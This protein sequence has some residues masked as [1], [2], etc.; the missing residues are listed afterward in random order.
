MVEKQKEEERL[1]EKPPIEGRRECPECGATDF[2]EQEDRSKILHQQ[3][4][5]KIYAKKT[6]CKKCGYIFPA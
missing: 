1:K 6:T 5:L 4:G 3:G 2:I